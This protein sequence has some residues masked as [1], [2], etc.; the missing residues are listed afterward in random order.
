MKTV[1]ISEIIPDPNQPRKYF[2]VEKM[3]SLKDSIKKH[4]IMNPIIVQKEGEK[5]LILDGERR[6][7]AASDLKLKEIPIE[8]IANKDPLTRLVEQFHIQEQHAEWSM[9]EKA[10]AILSI[11]DNT[12]KSLEEICELLSINAADARRYAAFA[13]LQHK[14]KFA[15][16]HIN[17]DNA[18]QLRY[19]KRAVKRIKEEILDEVFTKQMEGKFEKIIIE[20]ISRK[21]IMTR[22]DFSRIKDSFTADPKLID[23]FMKDEEFNID[24]HFIKSKARG[25]YH[26]RNMFTN[27][28]YFIGNAQ[29]FLKD[30]NVALTKN[31]LEH[32]KRLIKTAQELINLAE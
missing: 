24:E 20:M 2:A 8:V 5:F 23:K 30:K 21:E 29:G 16:A 31:D 11:M 32:L 19:L 4:G 3:A 25:A 13:A 27:S 28:G 6:F 26:Y 10:M 7:R 15:S 1:K 9:T 18:V 14:E 12:H 22:T 17:I